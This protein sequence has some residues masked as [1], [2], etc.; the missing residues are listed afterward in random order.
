MPSC[1]YATPTRGKW[2]VFFL[3]FLSY[4]AFHT[5]RKSFSNI[6]ANLN[7]PSCRRNQSLFS[8]PTTDGD[9]A[10]FCCDSALSADGKCPRDASFCALLAADAR[11]SSEAAGRGGGS[12]PP[13]LCDSWFG[14]RA[15]TLRRL[16]LMDTCFLVLYSA[17]LYAAGYIEDRVDK[18]L[19]LSLGMALGGACTVGIGLLGLADCRDFWPYL[20]LWSLNGLVQSCGWPGNVAVMGNW[21]GRGE[22]GAV[23]GVWSGNAS[24]G[25]IVGANMVALVLSSTE[26]V[27]GCLPRGATSSTGDWRWAIMS[28]GFFLIASALM[29]CAC[30]NVHPRDCGFPDP[31]AEEDAAAAAAA[32]EIPN[33]AASGEAVHVDVAWA[34]PPT[35][36]TGS[37]SCLRHASDDLQGKPLRR[38]PALEDGSTLQTTLLTADGRPRD[39]DSDRANGGP[40][41]SGPRAPARRKA[42][43]S[44]FG[45]LLIPSVAVY[46][47]TYAC[48]KLVNYC[49]FFWL[50]YYLSSTIFRGRTDGSADADA[51]SQLYDWGCVLGGGLG[52]W[53]SDVLGRRVPWRAPTRGIVVFA[54]LVPAVPAV[55]CL[56]RANLASLYGIIVAAGILVGGPA[57][58]ISASVSADLAFH[59]SLR[60][61][62]E[63]LATVAGI[64]DG[65]GSVGAAAGQYLVGALEQAGGWS[66]VFTLL[67]ACL[68]GAIVLLARLAWRDVRDLCGERARGRARSGRGRADAATE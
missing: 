68:V 12:T 45:A 29:M 33:S 53:A 49:I 63:A 6:K 18:R 65:T 56:L 47:L 37:S 66:A 13:P 54:M 64:I 57:T 40:L 60:G 46:S 17:G 52:G 1:L 55:L 14:S 38:L 19:V 48:V 2:T 35:A 28:T 3:T 62:A 7:T 58:L 41:L 5:T 36:S 22:R 9:P 26:A 39:E 43:I 23:L 8:K 24:M 32:G 4:T 50:P 34:E 67:V 31:N 16:A 44:F 21:F 20:A 15:A 30:I 25:N 51:L 42:P 61:D 27:S 11:G 10:Y 59:P